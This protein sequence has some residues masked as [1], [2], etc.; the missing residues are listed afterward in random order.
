MWRGGRRRHGRAVLLKVEETTAGSSRK[1]GRTR[2]GPYPPV[3]RLRQ[4]PDPILVCLIFFRFIFIFLCVCVC[5]LVGRRRRIVLRRLRRLAVSSTGENFRKFEEQTTDGA[6]TSLGK[7][8]PPLV[9][10]YFQLDS[11]ICHRGPVPAM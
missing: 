7:A 9:L 11:F 10:P 6:G 3:A 2:I 4:L 1:G 5:L 8:A